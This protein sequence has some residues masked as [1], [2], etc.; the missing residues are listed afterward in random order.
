MEHYS[1]PP[2]IDR[3]NINMLF[4]TGQNFQRNFSTT[5]S[6][7]MVNDEKWFESIEMKIRFSIIDQKFMF[8]PFGRLE[9]V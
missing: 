8:A 6:H 3:L 4:E 2:E 5:E 1:D 7:T 9:G